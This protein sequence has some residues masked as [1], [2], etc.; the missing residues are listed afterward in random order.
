MGKVCSSTAVPVAD[1]GRDE[2]LCAAAGRI[3]IARV[4]V[5]AEPGGIPSSVV[6]TPGVFA[7]LTAA[8]VIMPAESVAGARPGSLS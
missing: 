2:R 7:H 5:L 3:T 6:H 4:G 1:M 8:P